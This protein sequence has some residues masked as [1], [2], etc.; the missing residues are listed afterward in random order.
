MFGGTAKIDITPLGNVWM[1]GMIRSHRSEGVHDPLFARA[2]VLANSEDRAEAFAVVSV[3]ICGF[4]TEQNE[5]ARTATEAKT[6][7]PASQIIVAAT[8]T[9][10]APVIGILG[11]CG[12]V[13]TAWLETTK[14]NIVK[15]V[16]QATKNS[17]DAKLGCGLGTLEGLTYNRHQVLKDG[18]VVMPLQ[19]DEDL[20][21]RNIPDYAVR[22]IRLEAVDSTP[23]SIFT[24]FSCHPALLDYNNLLISSDYVYYT[25][26][27]IEQEFGGVAVFAT[28][29][30]GDMNPL[31]FNTT[32]DLDKQYEYTK[33]LGESL[34][35]E[36]LKVANQIKLTDEI[37]LKAVSEIIAAPLYAIPTKQQVEAL[38]DENREILEKIKRDEMTIAPSNLVFSKAG[39]IN[40]Q[41]FYLEYLEACLEK[42]SSGNVEDQKKVDMEIQVISIN[43]FT[44][45]G[46]PGEPY[47]AIAFA[48]Q[49]KFP[50]KKC[51]MIDLVN[52][53]D[54]Y[55]PDKDAH[56]D[57]GYTVERAHRFYNQ[58]GAFAPELEDVIVETVAKLIGV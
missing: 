4:S 30:C 21:K 46:V 14:S 51:V 44:I 26:E 35:K 47:V 43:E 15:A 22:V 19:K 10:S 25:R 56:G 57:G 1:D 29:A 5:A 20:I 52:G 49:E 42:L 7:I 58:L 55:I 48:I 38:L 32:D 27:I 50:N 34:G 41:S 33:I 28:A 9:H 37:E 16:E 18:A 36:A 13:D 39:Q 24:S 40:Y 17:V 23:I 53:S 3:D 12:S 31:H 45:I 2:L 54:G 6:G 11:G 8:H